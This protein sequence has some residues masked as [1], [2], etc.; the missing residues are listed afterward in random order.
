MPVNN[1]ELHEQREDYLLRSTEAA[2]KKKKD[3]C[4]W[5]RTNQFPIIISVKKNVFP[6]LVL[7]PLLPNRILSFISPS[8]PLGGGTPLLGESGSSEDSV[9]CDSKYAHLLEAVFPT[10]VIIR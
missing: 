1:P 8:T 9:L 7:A 10:H 6:H 5:R 3:K 4:K 2:K